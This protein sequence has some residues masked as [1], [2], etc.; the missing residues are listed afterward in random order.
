MKINLYSMTSRVPSG[1]NGNAM[2][3]KLVFMFLLIWLSVFCISCK[4]KETYAEKVDNYIFRVNK[5]LSS[6]D[7]E[8]ISSLLSE[9]LKG[10]KST[11]SEIE[12]V[13]DT[14]NGRIVKYDN[15][16]VGEVLD[17]G[18]Y[19]YRISYDA[20]DE[21]NNKYRIYIEYRN[22]NKDY[23]KE[24]GIS[25]IGVSTDDTVEVIGDQS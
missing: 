2:K 16:S 20:Y 10:K 19:T 5:C 14:V 6:K 13:F 17:S 3:K 15:E 12:K 1:F 24:E 21:F 25:Y 4:P 9:K 18:V 23:P 8:R 22:K 7:S 11:Q